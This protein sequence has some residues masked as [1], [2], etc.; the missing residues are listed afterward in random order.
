M[1]IHK[2]KTVKAL[3]FFNT[4]QNAWCFMLEE[5]QGGSNPTTHKKKLKKSQRAKLQ[6]TRVKAKN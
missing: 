1:S 4:Q 2:H 5:R 6:N 3:F